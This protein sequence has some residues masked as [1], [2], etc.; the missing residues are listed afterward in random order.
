MT[1]A[2]QWLADIAQRGEG[3]RAARSAFHAQVGEMITAERAPAVA[4]VRRALVLEGPEQVDPEAGP[5]PPVVLAYVPAA[6][7]AGWEAKVIRSLAA[8]PGTGL[9]EAWSLRCRRHDERLAAVWWRTGQSSA[10]NLGIYVGPMATGI[11]QL[12]METVAA[13]ARRIA[14]ATAEGKPVPGPLRR[15]GVLDALTG[16]RLTTT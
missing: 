6:L 15:R 9:V 12:G 14:K 11:E 1:S 5:L 10:F 2:E 16:V 13:R 3:F 8:V 7:G 4:T